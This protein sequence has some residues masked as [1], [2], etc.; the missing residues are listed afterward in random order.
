[1]KQGTQSIP[2]GSASVDSVPA[3]AW[4]YDDEE[5]PLVYCD[6][7]K[8]ALFYNCNE[9]G[10]V[11]EDHTCRCRPSLL[12]ERKEKARRNTITRAMLVL[13]R[14]GV[15]EAALEPIL[16]WLDEQDQKREG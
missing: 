5:T 2:E 1:M 10:P 9:S 15:P 16:R 4:I 12:T 11:C 3:C 6:T 8:P 13:Q 14:E 7:G